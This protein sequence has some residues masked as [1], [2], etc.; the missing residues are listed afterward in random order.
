MSIYDESIMTNEDKE[1]IK[2]AGEAYKKAFQSGDKQGMAD[3]HSRAEAIRKAYG[4]TGGKDGAGYTAIVGR[5]GSETMKKAGENLDSAYSAVADAYKAQ[6][7]AS[8]KNIDTQTEDVLR[9]AYISNMQSKKNIDQSLRA[10]G[11][12]GGLSETMRAGMEQNYQNNRISTQKAAVQAKK[13]V[14]LQTASALAQNELGRANAQ[15]NSDIANAQFEQSAAAAERTEKYNQEQ[16]NMNKEQLAITKEQH[17]MN[18]DSQTLSKYIS[19]VQNGLVDSKNSKDIAIALGTSEDVILRASKAAQNADSASV[20]L[21]LLS[22]GVYDDSFVEI[23]GGR[24]SASTLKQYANIAKKNFVKSSGSG[25]NSSSAKKDSG[26]ITEVEADAG[27]SASGGALYVVNRTVGNVGDGIAL[28]RSVQNSGSK[29]DWED[30]ARQNN[31]G[32]GFSESDWSELAVRTGKTVE[33]VKNIFKSCK[34][35]K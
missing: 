27:L 16:L 1:K 9:Q 6:A 32:E 18:K 24:F 10:S 14:D 31:Y 3:A 20:A 28:L 23:L 12:S 11:V 8:K 33:Q 17:Q 29:S 35:N 5:E 21:S 4:Y 34:E 22:G 19:F 2:L 13:D 7:E 30:T 25:R 26:T 15:Y